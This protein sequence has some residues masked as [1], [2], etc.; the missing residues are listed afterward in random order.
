MRFFQH[1][2]KW[3]VYEKQTGSKYEEK[4]RHKH[5]VLQEILL[6]VNTTINEETYTNLNMLLVH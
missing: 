2:T 1:C 5:F 3:E 4:K 6:N